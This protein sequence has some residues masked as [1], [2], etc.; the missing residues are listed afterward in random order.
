MKNSTKLSYEIFLFAYTIVAIV[1]F[2]FYVDP[3]LQGISRWRWGADTVIYM[4]IAKGTFAGE[5]LPAFS[6][7][8]NTFGPVLISTLLGNNTVLIALFKTS[9]LFL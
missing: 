3:S 1:L 8:S 4:D 2:Y 5:E 6:L 9:C 7:N